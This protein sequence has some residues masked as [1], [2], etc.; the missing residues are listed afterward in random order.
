[1]C[2]TFWLSGPQSSCGSGRL[3]RANASDGLGLALDRIAV[4]F[5]CSGGIASFSS[6]AGDGF[7]P[8]P[9]SNKARTTIETTT[10]AEIA[11]KTRKKAVSNAWA[12]CMAAYSCSNLKRDSVWLTSCRLSL[13]RRG[14]R[15]IVDRLD[16]FFRIIL[17][18]VDDAAHGVGLHKVG[19]VRAE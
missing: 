14:V 2:L 16:T 9:R 10:A 13:T 17:H 12:I 3:W 15:Y 19:I 6:R 1:M 7:L 4:G 5:D 8:K 11:T 18:T